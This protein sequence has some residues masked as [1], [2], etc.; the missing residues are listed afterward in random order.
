[1]AGNFK[2]EKKLDIKWA[3]MSLHW[4]NPTGDDFEPWLEKVKSLGYDGVTCFSDMGLEYFLSKPAALSQ[5]LKNTGMS[6]AAV[7]FQLNTAS[8]LLNP[9]MDLMNAAGCEQLVC[10]VHGVKDK[11]SDSYAAY[12]DSLNGVAEYTLARGI[13]THLHNNSDS[14]GRNL[15]DWRHLMPL[16]DW[17]YVFFMADTGH[18][19][20]DFDELPYRERA[21]AFLDANWDKLHLLE[22]KD[23][24][25]ITDLDTPLGEGLCDFGAIFSMMKNRG[26]TGWI[27][28]EQNQNNDLSLGRSPEECA[29]ISREFVRAGLGI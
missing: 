10:I 24:N 12:A 4:N 29:R 18:A 21:A 14:I 20:K 1:M 16:I 2:S 9:V 22:F 26:Y 27:T 8:T 15:T 5:M 3:S 19:T 23:Y 11:T 17:N 13:C 28:L 25:E 6:L 7:D